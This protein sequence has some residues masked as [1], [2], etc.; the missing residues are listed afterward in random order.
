SPTVLRLVGPEPALALSRLAAFPRRPSTATL[1]EPWATPAVERALLA[2]GG[3]APER[4]SA[5]AA[6]DRWRRSHHDRPLDPAQ[7]F[8]TGWPEDTAG[9]DGDARRV[10]SACDRAMRAWHSRLPSSGAVGACA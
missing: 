9:R 6:L 3:L 5:L 4:D 10:L 8:D 2:R 1:R 7:A